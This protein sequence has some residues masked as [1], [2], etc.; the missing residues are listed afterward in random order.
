MIRALFGVVDA[1]CLRFRGSVVAAR[2]RVP[3]GCAGRAAGNSIGNRGRRGL[4]DAGGTCRQVRRLEDAGQ[5]ALA[6]RSAAPP[7]TITTGYVEELVI[8]P[9]VRDLL[10]L[11]EDRS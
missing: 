11:C 5:A 4:E 3:V 6:A 10:T 1:V 8:A 2:R 9:A 7:H